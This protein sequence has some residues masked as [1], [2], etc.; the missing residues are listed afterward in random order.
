MNSKRHS[1]LIITLIGAVG[2]MTLSSATVRADDGSSN[3]EVAVNL[4]AG[5]T[6]VVKGLSAGGT[7]AVHVINNPNALIVH[8]DAPGELVL[9]GASAGQWAID[10]KTAEGEKVTYKVNVS[11]IAKPALDP[12]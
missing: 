9:L 7:P 5:E 1:G 12:G 8:G 10:V 6:Y 2:L 3:R 4:N 11:S